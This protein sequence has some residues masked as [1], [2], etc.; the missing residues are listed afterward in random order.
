MRGIGMS[1]VLLVA[2]T[3]CSADQVSYEHRSSL[4]T[5]TRG[6]ALLDSGDS[7]QVGMSGNTCEVATSS[8]MIGADYD[9]AMGEDDHV[10]DAFGTDV[11]VVG[12]SGIYVVEQGGTGWWDDGGTTVDAF[13]VD[14]ARF[15]E[16]GFAALQTEGEACEVTWYG[17]DGTATGELSIDASLCGGAFAVDRVGGTAFVGTP[18]ALAIV[19]PQGVTNG[20]IAGDL[21]AWDATAEAIYVAS[22]G[23]TQVHALAA[24]GSVRWSV[25]VG[26][27]VTSLDDMGDVGRVAVMAGTDEA[28]ELLILDGTT[29]EIASTLV[30]PSAAQTIVSSGDGRTMAMVVE[31]MGRPEVHFFGTRE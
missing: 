18:D 4:E 26:A 30:T 23:G 6:V 27:P 13:G 12:A 10:Q 20:A 8:G 2:A 17:T 15:T 9:V 29:G 11:I 25:D 7:A 31:S 22:A 14:E 21:V 28:G 16:S 3:G 1:L 5:R 24:D 19:T